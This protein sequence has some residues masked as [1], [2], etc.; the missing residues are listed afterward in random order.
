LPDAATPVDVDAAT[1]IADDAAVIDDASDTPSVDADLTEEVSAGVIQGQFN[2]FVIASNSKL[3]RCYQSATK[4]LPDDQPLRGE[5]DIALSVMPTG[6]TANVRID[7]D[8]IGSQTLAACVLGVVRG[9]AFSPHDGD[10]PIQ[11]S[12]PL[13]FG[14]Q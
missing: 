11:L 7:R 3:S 5:L 6:E 9:W 14:P 2:H 4:G 8:T 13:G 12:G 1:A 10:A